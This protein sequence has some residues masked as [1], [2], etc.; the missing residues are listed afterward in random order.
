MLLASETS[1]E[2]ITQL[3]GKK[4]WGSVTRN[5]KKATRKLRDIGQILWLD[6]ITRE[7]LTRGTLGCCQDELALSGLTSN[8]TLARVQGQKS[9]PS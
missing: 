7:V 1:P 6:R 4:G 8:P 2:P 5:I 9:G 3:T